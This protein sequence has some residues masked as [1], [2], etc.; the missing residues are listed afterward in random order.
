MGLDGWV[1]GGGAKEKRNEIHCEKYALFVITASA[2]PNIELA[3]RLGSMR[4]APETTRMTL[5]SLMF[6]CPAFVSR[7][8]SANSAGYHS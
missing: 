6:V 2:T 4:R 5:V 3:E 1:R 8:L 7:A